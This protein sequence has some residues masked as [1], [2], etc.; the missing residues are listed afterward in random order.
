MKRREEKRSEAGDDGGKVW[1]EREEYVSSSQRPPRDESRLNLQS[2]LS[3]NDPLINCTILPDRVLSPIFASIHRYPLLNASDFPW[4]SPSRIHP[5]SNLDRI[6][7]SR[8]QAS[9]TR[10][11]DV[12]G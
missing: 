5:S 4:T 1:E 3:P 9:W 8:S 10:S 12:A 11:G 7:F 2:T 6:V